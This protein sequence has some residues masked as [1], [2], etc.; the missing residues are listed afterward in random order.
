MLL[1]IIIKITQKGRRNSSLIII[2]TSDKTYH[3]QVSTGQ[4]MWGGEA[5]DNHSSC[6]S[7]ILE[8]ITQRNTRISGHKGLKLAFPDESR[9]SALGHEPV[10]VHW[11]YREVQHALGTAKMILFL[12]P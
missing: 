1:Y 9:G 4:F 8:W 10:L 7:S 5:P 2:T 12:W 6:P 3:I 11:P